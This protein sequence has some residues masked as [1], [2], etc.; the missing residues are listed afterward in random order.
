MGV[1]KLRGIVISESQKGESSKRILVLAKGIGRVVLTARGAKNTKSK[2]LAGTQLFSYCD[3]LAF[4]GKGFY[5]LTQADLIESFY[6]IRM[7]MDKLAE[8]VYLAELMERTCPMGMEQDETLKLLLFALVV[9][10]KT[11]TPPRLISR[12]FEVKYLQISGLLSNG[13]CMVCGAGQEPLFFHE[14]DGEFLCK[15]HCSGGEISLLP[16]VQKAITFI[17]QREGKQIF[18]F[19]L[20]PGA[21]MQM[22]YI[23]QRYLEVHMGVR[24]KSREFSKGL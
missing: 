1:V 12:I 3:F 10:E 18:A 20:S 7:D 15:E 19:T 23:L 14:K 22:D 16:A 21:M 17:T 24:L 11:K 9:L 8:A 6:G 4:E 5:S 13:G 2:L